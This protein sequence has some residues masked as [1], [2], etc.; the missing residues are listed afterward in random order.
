MTVRKNIAFPLTIKHHYPF[1]GKK[2]REEI[3]QKVEEAADAA[4]EEVATDATE[5]EAVAANADAE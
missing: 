5:S 2:V 4:T 1:Y 3:N